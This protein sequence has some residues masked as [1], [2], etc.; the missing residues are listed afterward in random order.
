MT[1]LCNPP[2]QASKVNNGCL[3]G[4]DKRWAEKRSSTFKFPWWIGL[5][6]AVSSYLILHYFAT[7][8]VVPSGKIKI[9]SM[10]VSGRSIR[11][12]ATAGQY[13]LPILFLIGSGISALSPKNKSVSSEKIAFFLRHQRTKGAN[14]A[15]LD[16]K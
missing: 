11:E 7:P 10:T 15:G 2:S 12:L 16:A 5:I 4:S 1:A 3:K 13:I 8:H 9:L 6:L 14:A